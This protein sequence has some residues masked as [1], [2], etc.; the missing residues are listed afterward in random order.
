MLRIFG[1]NGEVHLE[2]ISGRTY[3][4][5]LARHFGVDIS[6][7]RHQY[8]QILSKKQMI[9]LTLAPQW[10]LMPVTVRIPVGHQSSYGWIVARS[11]EEVK[12]EGK[13]LT[14]LLKGKH[15]IRVLHSE[16][17]LHRLLRN[18]QLV[19]LHYQIT[20]QPPEWVKEKRESYFHLF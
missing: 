8:G 4:N 6:S 10:T 15:Q 16:N 19:E 18:V 11:I 3:L 20:H 2:R 1:K 12:G 14:L 13:E 5:R 7:L 9:P 17:E